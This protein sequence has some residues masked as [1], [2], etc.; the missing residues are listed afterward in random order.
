MYNK[1]KLN[2]PEYSFRYRVSEK[3]YQIFDV[4]RKKYVALTPEEW[5]R[6]NFVSW[7]IH[8]KKY[9]MGLI[10][11]E[12]V[13]MLN[14]LKKRYDVVVYNQKNLPAMLIEC[15]APNVVVSQKVF[16]QAARYNL[17]LKVAFLVVT[18]GLEHFCCS[19]NLE[20][21]TYSFMNNIP[22]YEYLF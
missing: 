12:K 5:V 4:V 17:V 22:D 18:N 9:P 8:E 14:E 20:A 2:L 1:E 19:I 11:I 6:Q 16:D 3:H 15:K 13:L 10:A 7:L 21:N